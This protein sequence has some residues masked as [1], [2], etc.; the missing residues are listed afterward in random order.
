MQARHKVALQ[1]D[2]VAC[3]CVGEG[4]KALSWGSWLESDTVRTQCRPAMDAPWDL[5]T[6]SLALSQTPLT[7]DKEVPAVCLTAV[8]IG[9]LGYQ[10]Y[11][12]NKV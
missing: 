12:Y 3:M 10:P 4:I 1:G 7:L 2:D 5:P 9:A 6:S 8:Q 11:R